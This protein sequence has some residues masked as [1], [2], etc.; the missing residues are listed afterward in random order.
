MYN[1]ADIREVHLELTSKCQASCPMCPRN[2]Q[3]GVVNPWLVENEISIDQFKQWFPESFVNQLTRLYMCGNL[4]DAIVAKDTLKVFQYLRNTNPHMSLGF[5]T[6]GSAQTKKWWQ[7]LAELNVVVTFGIDGLEDT[8]ALYRVGTSF[9]KI[10]NNARTFIQ[11]GGTA[12][13]HM[14]VFDHNKH[15]IND[16]E[17]LS[18]E[19][20]FTEFTQ[21]NSSRFRGD[22]MPVLTK[23]GKTSHVIYPTE[24]STTIT[25]KLFTINLEEKTTIHCKA[26]QS[27]SIYVGADGSV[28]PCCWLDYAGTM[29]NSFSMVDYKDKGFINPNLNT[30][31]MQDIFDGNYFSLIEETWADK[32]LRECTKQC[33]KIDKLNEQFK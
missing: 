18:K 5:H 26:K 27:S 15:Q 7:Q 22:Y 12:R 23:D 24:K 21:K 19:L 32:P 25:K 31:S 28:T 9:D 11:A 8:H 20:G 3:G 13:W 17:K 33:G 6:N 16:C 30:S 1:Y 14:L 29:P 4:G 10:I 2:I